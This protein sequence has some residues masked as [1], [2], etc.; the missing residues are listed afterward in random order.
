MKKMRKS[1]KLHKVRGHISHTKSGRTISVRSYNRGSGTRF[2][3]KWQTKVSKDFPMEANDISLIKELAKKN[4]IKIGE[5]TVDGD[6]TTLTIPDEN[7]MKLLSHLIE[8]KT[9]YRLDDV[10]A[11]GSWYS[12]WKGKKQIML[13]PVESPEYKH[14]LKKMDPKM[15][16]LYESI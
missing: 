7:D 11:G 10:G 1:P 4:N 12:F 3:K 8:R 15:R 2:P 16:A 13:E 9:D 6:T 14:M 5:T